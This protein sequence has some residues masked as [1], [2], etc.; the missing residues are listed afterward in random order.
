METQLQD[1]QL[2]SCDIKF[3]FKESL[4]ITHTVFKR[5][6]KGKTIV[7]QNSVYFSDLLGT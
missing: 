3:C 6:E 2:I 1:L 7:T 5:G 4:K